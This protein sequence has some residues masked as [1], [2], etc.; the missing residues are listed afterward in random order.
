M[1]KQPAMGV[2]G[3]DHIK[4]TPDKRTVGRRERNLW[5]LTLFQISMNMNVI[6]HTSSTTERKSQE[7]NCN[8][9]HTR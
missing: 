6:V 8:Q 7:S 4:V 5:V 2:G 1:A 3:V 9:N